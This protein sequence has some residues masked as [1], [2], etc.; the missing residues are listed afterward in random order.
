MCV[1]YTV[2]PWSDLKEMIIKPLQGDILF[3][4]RKYLLQ[5]TRDTTDWPKVPKYIQTR[6]DFFEN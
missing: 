2:F 1:L 5:L 4:V 6:H 3:K